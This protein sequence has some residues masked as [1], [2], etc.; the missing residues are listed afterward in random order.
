MKSSASSQEYVFGIDGGATYSFGV[1]VTL[2][3]KVIARAQSGSL[4][5]LG[6]PLAATRRNLHDLVRNLDS[7]LPLGRTLVGAVIGSAALFAEAPPDQKLKLCQGLIPSDRTRLVSD[8]MTAYAGVCLNR[9]GVLIISG[10]GSVI[11][12]KSDAGRFFQTGGWGHLLGDEGSAY[13]VAVQ[14][15][16]AAIAA[17][18]GRGPETALV[19]DISRWFQVRDLSDIVPIIHRQDF[20]K[21]K[22][23]ALAGYLSTQADTDLVF[24][25]ICRDGG[26]SLGDHALYAIH[27]AELKLDP[28]PVYFNG[29]VLRKNARVREALIARMEEHSGIL[30]MEG[31]L[32]PMLGAAAMALVDAG[33]TLTPEVIQNLKE[34]SPPFPPPGATAESL[35]PQVT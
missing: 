14:S 23:A 25:E 30:V 10:T 7:Q 12:A 19:S 24:Q 29:S 33:I 35:S 20:N 6:S 31:H 5:F 21:E 2:E 9:P 22:M 17:L 1:A 13:W 3:G 8:C 15:I 16:R 26:K 28:V 34:S 11:L 18:E 4:N 27:G 32:A